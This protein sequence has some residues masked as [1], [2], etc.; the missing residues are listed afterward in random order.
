MT[1]VAL[2]IL[3]IAL[4]RLVLVFIGSAFDPLYDWLDEASI[5]YD[6]A[7]PDTEAEYEW[8]D[9]IKGYMKEEL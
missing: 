7:E 2:S 6:E 8:G 5:E 1:T 3:L 9:N 4:L